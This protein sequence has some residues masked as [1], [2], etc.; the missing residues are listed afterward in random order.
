MALAPPVLLWPSNDGVYASARCST[1][2]ARPTEPELKLYSCAAIV[3]TVQDCTSESCNFDRIGLSSPRMAWACWRFS[4]FLRVRRPR[5]SLAS[6]LMCPTLSGARVDQRIDLPTSMW[7]RRTAAEC[8]AQTPH[9]PNPPWSADHVNDFTK[10]LLIS[11]GSKL[12]ANTAP[13]QNV[14]SLAEVDVGTR[15]PAADA[16]K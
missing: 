1:R 8:H 3:V 13:I 2:D 9:L 7:P 12:G 5:R 16:V 10:L 6:T 11:R 15:S 4:R 14:D